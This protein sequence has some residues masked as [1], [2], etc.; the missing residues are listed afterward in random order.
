MLK[1]KRKYTD[2]ISSTSFSSLDGDIP[3][4]QDTKLHTLIKK[5]GC[6]IIVNN[7][8]NDNMI[9]WITNIQCTFPEK[10]DKGN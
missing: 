6:T 8:W 4:Q 7:Y 1:H 10:K 2:K 9:Q 5:S 3:G